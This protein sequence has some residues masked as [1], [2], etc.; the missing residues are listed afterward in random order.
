MM[1]TKGLEIYINEIKKLSKLSIL[2]NHA[3]DLFVIR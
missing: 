2:L 1:H 3:K